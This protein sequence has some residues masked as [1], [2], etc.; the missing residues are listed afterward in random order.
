MCSFIGAQ[1]QIDTKRSGGRNPLVELAQSIDILDGKSDAERELDAM[2]GPRVAD[3]W[4]D[5]PRLAQV[6]ADPEHGVEAANS[7][8]SF[9]AFSAMFGMPMPNGSGGGE[10]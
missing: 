3:D 8:G 10:A 7:P 4:R 5:D 1:A 2:R 6:A 9:E